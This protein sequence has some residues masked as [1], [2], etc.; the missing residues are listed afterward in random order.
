MMTSVNPSSLI[1]QHE[2]YLHEASVLFQSPDTKVCHSCST[3]TPLFAVLL[4]L[5]CPLLG[6]YRFAR[7][8]EATCCE[9]GSKQLH[10]R[11]V[12]SP[13]CSH[14]SCL[15]NCDGVVKLDTSFVRMAYMR[16]FVSEHCTTASQSR[17]SCYVS[18]VQV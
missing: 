18:Q 11:L 16:Q 1:S 4:K 17:R 15:R 13:S 2:W 5:R 3:C 14:V 6:F 9:T 7:L 10:L 8:A 12:V